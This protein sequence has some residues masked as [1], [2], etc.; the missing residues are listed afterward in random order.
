VSGRERNLLVLMGSVAGLIALAAGLRWAI[1]RP[2]KE[3]DGQ[4][5]V[6]RQDLNKIAAER[7]ACFADEEKIKAFTERTFSD[8]VDKAS[9]RSGEMLTK[10]ILQSGL[11]ESDFTRLP[12]GPTRLPGAN[13]IGWSVQGEGPLIQV[14]NLLFLLQESPYLHRLENVTVTPGDSAGR[15]R[16][17]FRFLTLVME[18]APTVEWR[19]LA[20]RFTLDS[21]ERLQ[22]DVIVVRDILRPYVKRAPLSPGLPATLSANDPRLGSLPLPGPESLRVVSLSQ[23]QGQA[24]VHVRDLVNQ[25]TLRYQSGDPLAGGIMVMVDYRPMPFPDKPALRSDSRVIVRMG[26]EYWA[27]ERGRTLADRHKLSS[28]QLPEDLQKIKGLNP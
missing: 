13:E 16:I 1:M 17:R 23:W 7:R 2:L 20:S 19:E 22:Y 24:E 10:L 3:L 25:R 5:S 28:E 4:I 6:L 9:A 27:I 14:V 8:D 18:P 21:P 12:A 26:A 11:P 15:V